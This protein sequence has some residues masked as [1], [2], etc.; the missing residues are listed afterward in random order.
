MNDQGMMNSLRD[1]NKVTISLGSEEVLGISHGFELEV[2]S[3]G[4]F[5]EHG[6]LL[7]F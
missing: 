1:K 5:E 3:G 2:V 7:S 6:V 4:I